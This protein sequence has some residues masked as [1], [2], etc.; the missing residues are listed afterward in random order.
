VLFTNYLVVGLHESRSQGAGDNGRT[1]ATYARTITLTAG[2]IARRHARLA[3]QN[4]VLGSG[5]VS[6]SHSSRGMF[7][8][9]LGRRFGG[10]LRRD[11]TGHCR[12]ARDRAAKLPE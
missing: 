9:V 2:R 11:R 5:N 10:P 4:G 7:L 3:L 6:V 8:A 12:N 1:L